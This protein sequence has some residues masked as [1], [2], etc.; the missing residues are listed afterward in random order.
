MPFKNIWCFFSRLHF[1]GTLN[2]SVDVDEVK[3]V[4]HHVSLTSRNRKPK[5]KVRGE[6]AGIYSIQKVNNTA[7]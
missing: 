2:F 5:V 6:T 4:T 1:V 3:F 7:T